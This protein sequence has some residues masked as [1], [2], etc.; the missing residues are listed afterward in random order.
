MPV[1]PQS[2]GPDVGP[3]LSL[4]RYARSQNETTQTLR[5]DFAAVNTVYARYFPKNPPARI[6]VCVVAW[7]GPFAI[8][9]DCVAAR[10]A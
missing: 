8:E 6:F 1:S 7:P 5:P 9:I 4:S 3:P 2:I 10:D